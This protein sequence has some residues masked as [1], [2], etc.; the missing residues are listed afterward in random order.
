MGAGTRVCALLVRDRGRSIRKHGYRTAAL[1]AAAL[2]S[3]APA[4]AQTP[5]A[6]PRAGSLPM[7]TV[8]PPTQITPAAKKAERRD[9]RKA[10]RATLVKPDDPE[11]LM[12]F[13]EAAIVF[14]DMEGAISALERLLLIAG[15]QPEV[16]LELAVL[17]FRIGAPQ[18]AAAYL[19]GVRSSATAS[20]TVRE[21]ADVY[22]AAVR[23]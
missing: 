13:A 12:G 2:L 20:A 5:G 16:K 6:T 7:P 3:C 22:L 8:A 18:T 15:D 19:E 11:T 9:Y 4:L 10:F 21:R 17:Y 14:G 23:R 1:I